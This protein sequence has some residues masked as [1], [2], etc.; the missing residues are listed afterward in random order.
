MAVENRIVKSLNFLKHCGQ[1]L[2]QL[3]KQCFMLIPKA[4]FYLKNLKAEE[5]TL[6]SLQLKFNG[7]RVFMS[8]GE[9]VLPTSWDFTQQRAIGKGYSELNFWLDKIEG[10]A[11]SIFRNLNIDGI[12]PTAEM[13]QDMLRQRIDNTPVAKPQ[14]Q[15][16]TL[17]RFIEQ[18]ICEVAATKKKETIKAYKTTL[19]HLANYSRLYNKK[20]DFENITMEFY[21]EFSEYIAKDLGNSKNTVAKQIKTIKTFLHEATDRGINTNMTFKSRNFKK[22]T[23]VVDKI[24]LTR[25][26]IDRIYALDLAKTKTKEFVRDLFIVSCYTGLRFSD[27]TKIKKE[28]VKNGQLHIRT[29]KT[30]QFVV[31]PIASIV[32]A[33][34]KKYSYCLPNNITNQKMNQYLKEIG[35]MAGINEP[36]VITKTEGGTRVQKVYKK[37]ELISAHCGRRSFATNA[38]KENIPSISIMKI[39]GHTSEKAFLGY[40]RISQEEN[41]LLLQDHSFFK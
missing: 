13:V 8:T 36:I 30:D 29:T 10:E 37:Y 38:Y 3:Q 35:Q 40:I 5:P 20:V 11:K 34:L 7:H 31:I 17:L 32:E 6:I 41:A 21:Y 4:N 19:N 23:E 12:T 14:E 24:Y 22:V 28:D 16:P 33:V 18:Y 25:E 39:T 15:K 26:E 9:K 1:P 2:G 27:F